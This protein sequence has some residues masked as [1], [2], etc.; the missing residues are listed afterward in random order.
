MRIDKG[1]VVVLTLA[2]LPYMVKANDIC[3]S[4]DLPGL[5]STSLRSIEKLAKNDN[6]KNRNKVAGRTVAQINDNP[7][8]GAYRGM[9]IQFEMAKKEVLSLTI[10]DMEQSKASVDEYFSHSECSM[11]NYSSSVTSPMIHYVAEDPIGK[12]DFL[13]T[14]WLYYSKKRKEPEVFTKAINIKNSEGET[15]LDYIETLKKKGF[16]S[17]DSESGPLKKIID[18]LCLHGGTYSAYKEKSCP[19]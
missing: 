15:L 19:R 12:Q 13:N 10:R 1:F 2:T 6:L 8:W 14:I 11:A 9:C 17:L 16:Y 3:I 18:T 7:N 4:C 5:P